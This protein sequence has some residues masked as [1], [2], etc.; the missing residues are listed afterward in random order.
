MSPPHKPQESITFDPRKSETPSH[1]RHEVPTRVD[2][3][4]RQTSQTSRAVYG[5]Q[6]GRTG[7]T[8]T[9][10]VAAGTVELEPKVPFCIVVIPDNREVVVAVEVEGRK[11]VVE[12]AAPV[13][14]VVPVE[15]PATAVD[16]KSV[17]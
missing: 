12:V 3:N 9:D 17:V 6:V 16:R 5:G 14:P 2:V 11:V 1:P 7:H 15:T 10:A 13:V 4:G 8:A